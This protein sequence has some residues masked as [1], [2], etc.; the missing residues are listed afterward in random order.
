MTSKTSKK[1]GQ[2]EGLGPDYESEIAS[3]KRIIFVPPIFLWT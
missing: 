3:V 2:R 1:S